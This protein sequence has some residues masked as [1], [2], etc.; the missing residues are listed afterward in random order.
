ML[1]ASLLLLAAALIATSADAAPKRELMMGRVTIGDLDLG[2]DTGAAR[3]L[4]RL[5]GVT[6]EMCAVP[7][8]QALPRAEAMEWRCR[9]MA[10]D[11]AIERLKAPKLTLAYA[12][13]LS[14]EPAAQLPSPRFR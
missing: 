1:R 6:R 2:T 7:R 4:Q 12:A 8:S 9:R 14:A 10:M 13:W 11:A 5:K 3:M